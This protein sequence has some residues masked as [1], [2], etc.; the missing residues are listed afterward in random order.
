MISHNSYPK[1]NIQ[2]YIGSASRYRSNLSFSIDQSI[3]QT[4]LS[5][6][7]SYYGVFLVRKSNVCV[8]WNQHDQVDQ[9]KCSRQFCDCDRFKAICVVHIVVSIR[10]TIS[11]ARFVCKSMHKLTEMLSNQS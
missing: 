6:K 11:S 5:R 4:V 2:P 9:I 8:Y 1:S 10:F 7:S 3:F